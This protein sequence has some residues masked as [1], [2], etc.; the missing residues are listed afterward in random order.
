MI[1]RS[2]RTFRS[3]VVR[4]S[5]EGLEARELLSVMPSTHAEVH[6]LHTHPH[7]PTIAQLTPIAST[8]PANGDVNPYGVAFVPQ[9]F[10]QGGMLHAGDILVS[11]FNNSSNLQGTGTTIVRVSSNNQTSVFF[12]RPQGPPPGLGLTTA[13]GILKRGFVVVGNVPSTDGTS[14]TAQQGS[15]IVLDK[16]GNEVANPTSASLLNGPWDLTIND[17]G[18]RAQIFVSNVLSGTVTRID[19]KLPPHGGFQVTDMLQIASGYTHMGDP[20]A[21]EIGPTGLVYVA[22]SDTLYV[23]STGDNAI[24]AIPHAGKTTTDQGIGKLVYQDAAHLHGPLGLALAPDGNF[25]TS[26]G[27]V[28]NSDPNQPSELVEFTLKGKFVGQFSL[29][30]AQGG[31]FGVA[32]SPPSQ[33]RFAAVNDITNSLQVWR[34]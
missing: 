27:D 20:A 6:A 13:L 18:N 23:A 19:V 10:P 26:N 12:Q 28:I 16:N 4:P 33:H 31:A 30:P 11:N 32:T 21:F 3:R 14:A 17:M 15:L 9:G 34:V 7:V 8:V 22:K 1:P 24:Y 29:N 25:I 5:L 2:S